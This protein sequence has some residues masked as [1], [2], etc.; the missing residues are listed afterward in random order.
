M[1]NPCASFYIQTNI[2]WYLAVRRFL[3][4]LDK[5][6][7]KHALNKKYPRFYIIPSQYVW[8]ILLIVHVSVAEQMRKFLILW[9]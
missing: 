8:D 3:I 5:K 9:I 4:L 7:R 1:L 2:V 6:I